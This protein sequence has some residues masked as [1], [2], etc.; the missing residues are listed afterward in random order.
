MNAQKNMARKTKKNFTEK[1]TILRLNVQR[2]EK[3][4][5]RKLL[6]NSHKDYV[7]H[8]SAI[9]GIRNLLINISEAVFSTT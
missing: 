9:T 1:Y 3:G 8:S 7:G 5:Y 4:I 2:Y 6:R